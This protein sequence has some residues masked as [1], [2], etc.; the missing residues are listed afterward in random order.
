MGMFGELP[1]KVA[2][3]KIWSCYVIVLF[4]ITPSNMI[5]DE[6]RRHDFN[7]EI[8]IGANVLAKANIMSVP[9]PGEPLLGF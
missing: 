8:Y 3:Q 2:C 6:P 7:V 4:G 5:R 1:K 9:K